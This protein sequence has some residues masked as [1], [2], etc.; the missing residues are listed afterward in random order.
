MGQLVQPIGRFRIDHTDIHH[1]AG[2]G[3]FTLGSRG[4]CGDLVAKRPVRP[5]QGQGQG[6][7]P[8]TE[9]RLPCAAR[10]GKL[11]LHIKPRR[12]VFR[13]GN[14]ILPEFQG[15]LGTLPIAAEK[16]RLSHTLPR[17]RAL[18]RGK[19]GVTGHHIV[20]ALGFS[21]IARLPRRISLFGKRLAAGGMAGLGGR[22]VA[23][24]DKYGTPAPGEQQKARQNHQS[25]CPCR[26]FQ[27]TV[28]DSP[29]DMVPSV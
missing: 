10:T 12:A 15:I 14:Q 3:Q 23:A 2:F 18:L 28:H 5:A 25:A 19:R 17:Q 8:G 4:A 9:R 16:G 29:K 1:H 21:I 11:A 27:T 7:T 24:G 22:R 13:S 6:H 26:P 20:Q